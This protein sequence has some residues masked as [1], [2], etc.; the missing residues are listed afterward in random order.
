MIVKKVVTDGWTILVIVEFRI[1]QW[2]LSVRS[3]VLSRAVDNLE[4]VILTKCHCELR[5]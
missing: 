3:E 5:I 2:G 1:V 4:T